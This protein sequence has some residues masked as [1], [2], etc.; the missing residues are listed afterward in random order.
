VRHR[1]GPKSRL[2]AKVAAGIVKC[3]AVDLDLMIDTFREKLAEPNGV[4]M[5]WPM[6]PQWR[7]HLGLLLKQNRYTPLSGRRKS[8]VG[9]AEKDSSTSA[10]F[11]RKG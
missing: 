11:R 3:I 1:T 7:K 9:G 8:I 4:R 10:R 6:A 2:T 5:I